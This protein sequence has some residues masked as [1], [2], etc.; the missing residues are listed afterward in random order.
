[1][2][3]ACGFLATLVFSSVAFPQNAPTRHEVLNGMRKAAT[4]YADK[5]SKDGGYHFDYAEDLSY[6]RSEHGQGPTQVETQRDGTPRVAMAFLEA[7]D[8]TGDRLYLEAARKAALALVQGQLCSGGWDYLIEFDPAARKK[9]PYRTEYDCAA[10]GAPRKPPTSLDDNITQACTRVLMR[11]DR[12]LGFKDRAI[13][14]AAQFALESLL[15]AQYPIGAWPQRYSAFPDPAKFPVKPASYPETWPRQWPGEVYY[16]HYTFNDNSIADNIDLMLEAALVYKDPR[17]RAAAERGGQFLLLAQMP[18]PQPGWAQQYDRDMHPAWARL[19]EPPSVTG[20]ESHSVMEMLLLLYR[21]TGD[22]KYLRPFPSAL[23]YYERSILPPAA[24]PSQARRRFRP[25]EPVLARFYELRTNRPLYITKGNVIRAKG[26]G[27]SRADGYEISYTDE[28]V[29]THYAVLTSGAWVA[30]VRAAYE[31]LLKADAAGL[32]R[33]GKLH[34]LSPWSTGNRAPL[35]ARPESAKVRSLLDSMDA[36]GAWAEMGYIGKADRLIQLW[37][38]HDGTM[39]I[40]GRITPIK[41]DD[42]IEIYEGK[43]PPRTRIIR[44]PTFA[45]NLETLA[46]WIANN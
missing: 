34:G 1:M 25:G 44:S 30:E 36:R 37:A 13:H 21:E 27:T 15:K 23:A 5:V 10:P 17:L 41:E 18:E 12:A 6:G 16:E 3:P 11:V 14:E 38:A 35:A 22:R 9:Y 19:F 7:Y 20:G 43:Q 42:R 46:A 31:R 24:N 40:N 8:A 26:L 29:I 45:Q 32:R 33:G 39:V 28:S 2:R 4:F